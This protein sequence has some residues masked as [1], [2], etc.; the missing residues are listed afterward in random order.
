I[1]P[2]NFDLKDGVTKH[3][4]AWNSDA[5][6]TFKNS[7]GEMVTLTAEQREQITYTDNI[8]VMI[9]M[10]NSLINLITTALIA[11][12]A[13]SLVVSCFMIA[14]ITYVSVV[15][16]VKEIGVIRSLGGRKK[17]VT[18]LFNAETFIIGLIS[19]VFGIAVTYLI[20]LILNIIVKNLTGVSP[21]AALPI[22]QAAIMILVSILLTVVSGLIPARS[23]AKKDP[24]VALRT[25]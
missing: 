18:H 10:I 24:V 16:R 20:S 9:N 14:I 22:W 5:T 15:E 17:D 11:F 1:Y 2:I 4:D 13:L 12:T 19:G 3:L 21:I 23:A 8:A 25:E 7:K 6:L